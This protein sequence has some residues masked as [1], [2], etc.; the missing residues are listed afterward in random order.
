MTRVLMIVNKQLATLGVSFAAWSSSSRVPWPLFT[1]SLVHY[2]LI[3]CFRV[4][5]TPE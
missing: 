4:D 5:Y 1:T 2:L 3:G